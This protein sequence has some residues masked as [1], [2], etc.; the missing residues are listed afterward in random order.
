MQKRKR[1]REQFIGMSKKVCLCLQNAE[2][3]IYLPKK[4]KNLLIRVQRSGLN[5]EN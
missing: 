4:H 5:G 2:L 3:H 1:V